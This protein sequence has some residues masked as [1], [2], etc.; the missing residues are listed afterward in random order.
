MASKD[1]QLSE[2]LLKW[3]KVPMLAIIG[4]LDPLK[5]CAIGNGTRGWY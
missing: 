5:S 3:I 1:F 2:D 4:D